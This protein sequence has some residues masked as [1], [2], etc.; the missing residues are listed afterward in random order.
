MKTPKPSKVLVIGSAEGRAIEALEYIA[1]LHKTH[2]F[3]FA[4]CLGNLFTRKTASSVVTKLKSEKFLVPLPVYFGVGS[5][6]MPETVTSHMAMYGPEICPNLFCMG[7]CG[8]MKTYSRFTIAQLGGTYDEVKFNEPMNKREK[9]LTERSFHLTDVQTL[10]KRCD[11][12]FSNSWPENV[13]NKSSLPRRNLPSGNAPVAA[14]AANCMPQYFF[15]PSPVYYERE[16]Y[17]NSAVNVP[18]GTVSRFF[19]IAPFKNPIGEKFAYAFTLNP[20]TGEFIGDIPPNCTD[21]PFVLRPIPLKRASSEQVIPPP[22][23]PV[24]TESGFTRFKKSKVGPDACFFCLSN[25]SISL[26]LIVAIGNEA[27][28]ALPKGPLTTKD[29]NVPELPFPAHVLIIPIAHTSALSLLSDS[30]Y[31]NTVDELHRFRKAVTQMYNAHNSDAIVYE[32]SRANGVHVHWQVIPIPKDL[33]PKALEYFNNQA[34]ESGFTFEER[35]LR[36]HELNYFRV[37]LPSGEVLVHTLSLRERFDLQFG[38]RAA[39]KLMGIEE[40][41]DWRQCNQT[42][43]EEKKDAEDFKSYFKPYDFT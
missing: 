19:G 15:V 43:E 38:R 3:K 9:S 16:P 25:S 11:I 41:I 24:S 10:S 36:S 35:D 28:M 22:D 33:S 40:R 4:I 29:T 2:N 30:S 5:A 31:Q 32:I 13:Q 14:L 42:E 8:F 39:A 12:L 7:I 34:K 27:Y 6:G 21:S 26:H 20:L 1:D 18:S 37:F 17:R 23:S